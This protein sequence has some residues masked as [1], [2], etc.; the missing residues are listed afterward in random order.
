VS[1]EVSVPSRRDRDESSLR[2]RWLGG[3]LREQREDRGLTLKYVANVLG[4][5]FAD[6]AAHEHGRQVFVFDKV[7]ALLDLYGIYDRVE[8]DH[9]LGLARQVFRLPRWQDDFAGPDLDVS[10]LDFLWLESVAQR[11]CCYGPVLIPELLRTPE[12]VEAVVRRETKD[13]SDTQVG[14]WV[15][16][17]RDRQ[18]ALD[19]GR[20][21]SVRAVLAESVLRRPVGGPTGTR[22]GQLEHLAKLS[23]SDRIQVRVLPAEV[24]YVPWADGWFTVFEL[25]EPYPQRVACTGH[26]RGVAIHE[27]AVADGYAGM[28]DRLWDAATTQSESA[29]LIGGL[30]IDLPIESNS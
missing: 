1:T 25:P 3:R 2:S 10:M 27:G 24:G 14:W 15:R 17:Y 29:A 20:V 7:A 11:I 16:I 4:V 23:R 8:R 22:P 19:H 5:Q 18:Q 26:A 6:L 28:F 9:L 30:A 21:T 13:V 12:Y